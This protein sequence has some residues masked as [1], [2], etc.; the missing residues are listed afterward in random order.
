MR[1]IISRRT[2]LIL[3]LASALPSRARANMPPITDALGRTIVL[4][5]PAERIIVSFNF[6]EFTAVAGAAGWQRV[7][8]FDRHQWENN[9]HASWVRYRAAIPNHSSLTDI[10]D[11]ERDTF[12]VERA[13]SLK[14]DLLIT[15]AAGYSSRAPLMAQVE[16]AGIPILVV[17]YNAQTVEK[18]VAG[19][20]ALGKATANEDRARALADLYVEQLR[21][22]RRRTEGRLRPKAYVELGYG[23]AGVVGNTY[24]NAM[25]GRM[26]EFAGGANIASARIP[27]G[28]APMSPEY[29]LAAAPEHIFITASSWANAPNAVRA[30]YDCSIET[31]QRTLEPYADRPGW[32]SLPAIRNNELHAIE[33]G[34]ARSLWD[35]TGT[36]YIA[37]QLHPDAFEDVDPVAS[38]RHYH[39]QFLPVTFEGCW[40]ARLS[41]SRT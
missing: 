38:L 34:L 27:T 32:R 31:T 20:L 19:T 18:H 25:W 7:V 2:C 8:G 33:T 41:P 35:W 36:Q 13:L 30:G 12:S 26:I 39:E 4:K 22:I 11:T 3:P 21:D 37:K 10:G 29:V 28:W 24:N 17:D 6:E 40:M 1:S 16:Q 5:A 15:L 23:G 14:P 9:R